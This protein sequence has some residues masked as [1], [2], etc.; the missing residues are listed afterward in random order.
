ML[1]PNDCPFSNSFVCNF[2][3]SEFYVNKDAE[4]QLLRE[5]KKIEK[6]NPKCWHTFQV[7]YACF[8]T[9][10]TLSE[11]NN[12]P[13]TFILLQNHENS[14]NHRE[15]AVAGA[16]Q[17]SRLRGKNFYGLCAL[18]SDLWWTGIVIKATLGHFYQLEGRQFGFLGN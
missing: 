11:Q 1:L 17:R 4:H 2:F 6:K 16:S 14:C 15:N 8:G 12:Q 18:L 5:R 3:Y 7:I 9:F 13:W 10:W